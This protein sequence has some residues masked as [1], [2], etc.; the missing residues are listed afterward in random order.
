[1][2]AISSALLCDYANVRDNMLT[3]VSGGLT[4]LYRPTMPGPL[5]MMLA[6]VVEVPHIELDQVHELSV[7]ITSADTAT[8]VARIVAGLQ[9]DQTIVEPGESA[10]ACLALDIRSVRL[11]EFGAYDVFVGVDSNLPD[12]LTFYVKQLAEPEP[13]TNP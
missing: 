2:A 11:E 5:S 8:E 12:Q 3:V 1:V 10:S 6:I 9:L 13:P 4:R 7:K